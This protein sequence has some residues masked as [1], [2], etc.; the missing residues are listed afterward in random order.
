MHQLKLILRN[1]YRYRR[2]TFVNIIGLGIALGSIIVILQFASFQLSF[3]QHIGENVFRVISTYYSGDEAGRKTTL[4]YSGV[5]PALLKDYPVI[6]NQTRDFPFGNSTIMAE[7]GEAILAER[8][9]AV[10]PSFFKMFEL[11]F[12]AGGLEGFF[13]RPNQIILT[14]SLAN[15]VFP[16]AE[17]YA[18]MY[19]KTISRNNNGVQFT[20]VG[21]IEDLP[22]NMHISYDLFMSYQTIIDT[23][24]FPQASF[25]WNIIDFR[26][27]V[28]VQPG[29]DLDQLTESIQSLNENYLANNNQTSQRFELQPVGEIYLSDEQI[30]YDVQKKGDGQGLKILISLGL[31]LFI[32][33]WVNFTNLNSALAIEKAKFVGIRKI[34]GTSNKSILFNQSIE[35]MVTNICA[36]VIGLIFSI[37]FT[38]LLKENGFD[39][40]SLPELITNGFMSYKLLVSLILL[41]LLVGFLSVLL[42][43][44]I[45]TSIKP[46]DVLKS[47]TSQKLVKSGS[48]NK[49]LIIFQFVLS[50]TVFSLNTVVFEQQRH[51]ISSPLGFRAE[52]LW[53][54]SSPR[55][56]ENDSTFKNTLTTFKSRLLQNPGFQRVTS[57][58]RLPGQLLQMDNGAEYKQNPHS[59]NYLIVDETYINTFELALLA[60][61]DFSTQ[62]VASGN[63]TIRYGIINMAAVAELGFESPQDAIGESLTIINRNVE[64]IGVVGN[65][66]QRTV[67]FDYEPT[68]LLP[69]LDSNYQ[70]VFETTLNTDEWLNTVKDTYTSSFPGNSFNFRNFEVDYY[71]NYEEIISINKSLSI[72]SILTLLISIFGMT[73]IST[74]NL[75]SKL[76]E[77]G[78]RKVLGATR[79][80]L[81]AG[82][83]KGYLFNILISLTIA[84]PVI[85]LLSRSWLEQFKSTID[86]GPL[87]IIIPTTLLAVALFI[88][89]I[90]VLNKN[91]RVNPVEVLR[92]Q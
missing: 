85:Y 38:W 89:L 61:R 14:E 10:E 31:I 32:I 67:D 1:L 55:L 11:S 76:Q 40:K 86:F 37:G 56:T 69:G 73:S 51:V 80:N 30:D 53:V 18:D 81:R 42:T 83:L 15:A 63:L 65:Y 28:E 47:R 59:L 13:T 50:I 46:T 64:I 90:V 84:A 70:I 41:M 57:G 78:I 74:L 27:Y 35:L 34:L 75:I 52:N 17:S 39:I 9:T 62:N 33:S 66:R 22:E 58:Q 48:M 4:T 24:S 25:D 91:I 60:G 36:L 16:D 5:G 45:S 88:P 71:R 92:Q 49:I 87:H 2:Y 72:F 79:N 3:D 7:G 26:H 20:V 43:T 19:N 12:L 44:S 54:L 21:I 82:M 8:C 77:I 6:I 68:V 29:T 23:W